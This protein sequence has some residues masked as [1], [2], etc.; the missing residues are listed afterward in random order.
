MDGGTVMTSLPARQ[1]L[2]AF[3]I[4]NRLP[5]GCQIHIQH[6]DMHAPHL[7]VGELAVIDP[8][9][10]EP[11]NGELYLLQQ[12][13]GPIIWQVILRGDA[14]GLYPLDRPTSPE[15]AREWL[16]SGRPL[17]SGDGFLKA[18]YLPEMMLGRVIGIYHAAGFDPA[19]L[20][21]EAGH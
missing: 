6:N 14:V 4:F 3:E 15:Q 10:R 9:D 18:E 1:T 11:V 16:L 8:G 7:R 5:E 13:Q 12:S 17:Y 21:E 19:A 2:R 20:I